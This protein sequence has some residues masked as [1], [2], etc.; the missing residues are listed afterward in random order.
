MNNRDLSGDGENHQYNNI[1]S[2]QIQSLPKKWVFRGLAE[3]ITGSL[4]CVV[5]WVLFH[6]CFFQS[7]VLSFG[8]CTHDNTKKLPKFTDEQFSLLL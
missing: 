5:K 6:V 7:F 2:L 1:Q 8:D 3:T 4:N